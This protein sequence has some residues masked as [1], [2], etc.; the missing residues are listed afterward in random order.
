[1]A[2]SQHS[3]PKFDVTAVPAFASASCDKDTLSKCFWAKVANPALSWP[4]MVI[5]FPGVGVK[6]RQLKRH[7]DP[8]LAAYAD[9][10]KGRARHLNKA[11]EPTPE[12]QRQI[13]SSAMKEASALLVARRAANGPDRK[14]PNGQGAGA[15]I[16]AMHVKYPGWQGVTPFGLEKK[17]EKTPGVSPCKRLLSDAVEEGTRMGGGQNKQLSS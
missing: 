10:Q 12:D 15:I 3:G 2:N 13:H 5:Q 16:A 7:L 4:K 14:L 1:M 11:A 9:W 6:R 17:T 8:V